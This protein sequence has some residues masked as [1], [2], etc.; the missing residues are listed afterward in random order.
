[1]RKTCFAA[2]LLATAAAQAGD[3]KEGQWLYEVKMKGEGMGMTPEQQAEMAAAQKQMEEMKK[4]MPPGF[5]MPGMGGMSFGAE[6]MTMKFKKCITEKDMVPPQKEDPKMKCESQSTTVGNRV[7]FSSHCV[8]DGSNITTVGSATYSGDTMTSQ[9]TI[10]GNANGQ[11][12]NNEMDMTG[13]YLGECKKK[14]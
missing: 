8:G 4:Q 14:G 12:I 10:K 2:A 6:G 13:K 5:K 9:V 7:D 1:M 11:P 3:F